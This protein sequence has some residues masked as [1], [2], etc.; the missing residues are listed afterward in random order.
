V[1]VLAAAVVVFLKFQPWKYFSQA[2]APISQLPFKVN[3]PT[4]VGGEL[5]LPKVATA[6]DTPW[7]KIAP[8]ARLGVISA[9]LVAIFGSE[10]R[11][12][13]SELTGIRILGETQNIGEKFVDGFSPVIKFLDK[14]SKVLATKIARLS[15]GFDF[16]GLSPG[17]KTLYDV[18][19]ESPPKSEK[20][21]ISLHGISATDSASV[22]PLKIGNKSMETKSA[23]Y[24]EKKS[25]EAAQ[26]TGQKVQYFT[27][28]GTVVN[29]YPEPVSEIAIYVWVRDKDGKVFG[30]SRQDFKNDL[31][32]SS[33]KIEF[34]ITV[35]P[36]KIDQVYDSYELAAWG[37]RYKLNL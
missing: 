2:Q 17:E 14:D 10:G 32:S 4:I 25:T 8:K 22:E 16:Y 27:I 19:V 7:G 13:Q 37:R 34:K 36:F 11:S 31:L 29:T 21:E 18:T 12:E 5:V 33:D 20:L 30:F 3:V 24:Q 28:S 23:T 35:L 15:G 9:N 26:E 1:L 6:S